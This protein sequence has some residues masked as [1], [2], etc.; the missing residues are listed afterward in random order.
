[1]LKK[2]K[3]HWSRNKCFSCRFAPY[4]ACAQLYTFPIVPAYSQAPKASKTTS[5]LQLTF[6]IFFNF[7]FFCL[8]CGAHVGYGYTSRAGAM[9]CFAPPFALG[10]WQRQNP[11]AHSRDLHVRMCRDL[12][13]KLENNECEIIKDLNHKKHVYIYI[14]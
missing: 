14:Y 11:S 10:F 2:K 12:I 6:C 5:T 13:C 1:M 9:R 3:R 4:I 8:L 7:Y